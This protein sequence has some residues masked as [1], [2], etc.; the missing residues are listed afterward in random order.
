[1]ITEVNGLALGMGA[2]FAL[3][4]DIRIMADDTEIG[5]VESGIGLLAAAGGTQRQTRIVGTAAA[6]ELLL[7]GSWLTADD[8]A[9]L[10]IVHQVCPRERLRTSTIELAGRLAARSPAVTREIKRAVYDASARPTSASMRREAA[11]LV[12]TLTDRDT[13]RSMTDYRDY[14]AANAPLTD[15]VI[16][17]G[18]ERVGVSR[19]TSSPTITSDR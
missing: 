1:M 6:V 9:R 2:I 4:C 10:G 8:A 3:A 5:L 15:D 12:R 16:L 13:K 18:W 17:R 7:E 11:G 14:L 19:H